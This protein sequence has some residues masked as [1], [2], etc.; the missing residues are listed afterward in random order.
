ML[1]HVWCT[2]F[3]IFYPRLTRAITRKVARV[4]LFC[5]DTFHNGMLK[6]GRLKRKNA[7]FLITEETFAM[8]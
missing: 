6:K 5:V 8:Y 7:D 2:T 4:V 1:V 3:A